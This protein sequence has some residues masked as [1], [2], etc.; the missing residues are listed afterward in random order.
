M[1][2]GV[3]GGATSSFVRDVPGYYWACPLFKKFERGRGCGVFISEVRSICRTQSDL[4]CVCQQPDLYH[5]I[6]QAEYAELKSD[7]LDAKEAARLLE[8]QHHKQQQQGLAPQ[9]Q[10]RLLNAPSEGT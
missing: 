2:T 3:N 10:E 1:T 7:L 9:Q 6:L 8:E 5:N 4:S